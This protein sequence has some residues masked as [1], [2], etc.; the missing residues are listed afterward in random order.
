MTIPPDYSP[1]ITQMNSGRMINL[2]DPD[3]SDILISDIAHHLALQPR[4]NGAT[5]G[6]YSVAQHSVIVTKMVPIDARPYALFHDA[7]EAFI[8]DITSPTRAAIEH[9]G[10]KGALKKLI[11]V[12]DK[13]IH[14][15]FGLKWPVPEHIEKVVHHADLVALATEKRDLLA[16]VSWP[17]PA[18]PSPARHRIKPTNWTQAVDDFTESYHDVLEICPDINRARANIA[19]KRIENLSPTNPKT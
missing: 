1:F 6:F 7:H 4:F 3:P 5:N 14:T 11:A 18:L 10:G 12:I 17:T 13:A 2:I 15:S 16:E 9:F 8:G 19:L